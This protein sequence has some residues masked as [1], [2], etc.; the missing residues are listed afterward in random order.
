MHQIAA[1]AKDKFCTLGI[2]ISFSLTSH[3]TLYMHHVSQF[4]LFPE[5]DHSLQILLVFHLVAPFP[6]RVNL[7]VIFLILPWRGV[8]HILYRSKLG[9]ILDKQM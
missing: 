9:C 4:L 5:G 8:E 3:H 2:Y 1:I 6:E 7:R